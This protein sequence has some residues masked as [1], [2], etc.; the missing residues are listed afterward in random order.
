MPFPDHMQIRPQRFNRIL[1]G[2]ALFQA[3]L[4]DAWVQVE[5][6]DLN[7]LRQNQS[8]LRSDL[9]N[10]LMDRLASDEELG[11]QDVGKAMTILPSSFHGGPRYMKRQ[12]QNA[13]ALVVRFGKPDFFITF[14]CNP[15]WPDILRELPQCVKPSERADLIVRVFHQKL[16]ELITDLWEREIF[17]RAMARSHVIEFQKRGLPH[18][19]ILIILSPEDRIQTTEQVDDAVRAELPDPIDEPELYSLV[20]THMMHQQCSVNRTSS[21]LFDKRDGR[22]LQCTKRFPK[23]EADVTQWDKEGG[24]AK[25]RRRPGQL[26]EGKYWSNQWVVP[27]NPYLL[28]KY[29]AHINVE[30]CASMK[31]VAYLFKYIYKGPDH[32][33]IAVTRSADQDDSVD[34]PRARYRQPVDA[35]EPVDEI[36]EYFTGRWIGSCEAAWKLHGLPMGETKPHVEELQCHLPDQQSVVIH[37]GILTTE[38]LE[39]NTKARMTTLTEYFALNEIAN[40]CAQ[41]NVP[42]PYSFVKRGQEIRKD[43]RDYLYTEI[44]EHFAWVKGDRRWKIRERQS[45][46]GRMYFI[47]PKAGDLYHLRMLLT[48]RRGCVS[49]DDLRTVNGRPCG[50]KEACY[51]LGLIQDDQEHDECLEEASGFATGSRLRALFV[52]ILVECQPVDPRALW[53]RFKH[54]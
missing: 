7:W 37:A 53:D 3:F 8:Q 13:M 29:Q 19:H 41:S 6:N 45:A 20:T 1:Y 9:Y 44:P 31:S 5:M 4:T 15:Q 11:V 23:E 18:A 21:C 46:I 24:Y 32:A 51:E 36:T 17:G 40:Q 47:N 39:N 12:F 54:Q 34:D 48:H 49:F 26:I 33:D 28:R 35:R 27:Y 50:W 25:Y 14:T 38:D 30:V 52:D 22:G 43:P 16:T 10:G 2:G 42:W